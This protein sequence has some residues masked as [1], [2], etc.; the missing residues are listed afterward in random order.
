MN[1]RFRHGSRRRGSVRA[2]L[3]LFPCWFALAYGAHATSY[4]VAKNG[5]DSNS[6]SVSSPWLTIGHAAAEAH[7]G[8]TVYV[9][10][11]TYNE[12]DL[13][14]NSGTATAPIVFNGQGVAIVD[15]TGVACCTTP[16]FASSNSFLCCNT[17]GLFTIGATSGVN[18]LTIEGFTIQNY[19]TSSKNDVPAGILIAGGGT[20]INILNNTV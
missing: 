10:A 12:S 9:G 3:L 16:S 14:A 19:K 4:Y 2:L 1:Y 15:G 20:G 18:Y 5:S 17:Q 6:G 7:A 11:G 13:F 8:D